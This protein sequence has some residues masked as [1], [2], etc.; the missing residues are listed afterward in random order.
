LYRF[1]R[2]ICY[3]NFPAPLLP[4]ALKDENPYGIW[5]LVNGT[6]TKGAIGA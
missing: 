5:R 2:P 4:E 3:Q 1:V 6:L